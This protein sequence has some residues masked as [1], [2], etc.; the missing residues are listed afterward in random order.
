MKT[1]ADKNEGSGNGGRNVSQTRTEVGVGGKGE[2]L[3]LAPIDKGERR[4]GF[5]NAVLVEV[6]GLVKPMSTGWLETCL[7][8]LLDGVG[9]CFTQTFAARVAPFERIIGKEFNM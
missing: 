8:E 4:L 6:D 7:L 1:V 2:I 3:G 9:L 5:V